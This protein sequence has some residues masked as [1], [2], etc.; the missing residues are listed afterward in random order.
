M[1]LAI[2]QLL[3]HNPPVPGMLSFKLLFHSLDLLTL[4]YGSCGV[5]HHAHGNT[6][7]VTTQFDAKAIF[8]QRLI[9]SKQYR[10]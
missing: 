6:V 3:Q 5:G 2:N 4:F 7:V 1:T 8:I 9:I 10:G